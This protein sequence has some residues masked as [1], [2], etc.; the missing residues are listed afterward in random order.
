M[1]RGEQTVRRLT[2]REFQFALSQLH[3]GHIPEN[4][5]SVLCHIRGTIKELL[6]Y[7]IAITECAVRLEN[8]YTVLKDILD[9]AGVVYENTPDGPRKIIKEEQA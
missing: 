1:I 4:M 5:S 7:S 3:M 9:K 6:E 2:D 8:N